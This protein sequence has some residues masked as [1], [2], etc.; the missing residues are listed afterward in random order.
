MSVAPVKPRRRRSGTA[1]WHMSRAAI[2]LS[3]VDVYEMTDKECL[4]LLVQARFGGWDTVRCPKCGSIDRHY[5]RF[6]DRRWKCKGCDKTFS[7]TSDSVFADRKLKLQDLLAGALLWINSSAGQPALELKRHF[8]KTYN[9][10]Y[11]L[12]H[13]LRE[14]LIRGYNVGLLNGDIEI[15]GAHQSGHRSDEKR[16]RPQGGKR[17][18]VGERNPSDSTKLTN[19]SRVKERQQL[20][21]EG[22]YDP[23]FHKKLPKDRRFFISVRKR[24]GIRGAGAVG[25]RVAVGLVED[26]TVATAVINDFVAKSESFL[27]T[28]TANAYEEAG[29]TFLEHR[30]VEHSE[31]L[32]GPNGENNN[33]A[34]ELNFRLDR[35]EKG[36]H[37]NIEPKY[38]LDYAVEMAFRADTRRM[39]NGSALRIALGIALNVG[40]SHYWRGFTRGRHRKVELLHPLPQSAPS[41][42]PEKGRDPLVA[43]SGRHPR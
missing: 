17:V 22:K 19:T 40:L 29:M 2:N 25:T 30:T 14:A 34:E 37:L 28:D 33:L 11:T 16:G 8:N 7:I 42:G 23:D 21:R 6:L 32:I 38:M 1:K 43:A 18:P 24:S 27:N 31:A 5:W 13:K 15:D 9:T 36:I 39:P 12:Q 10:A 20:I 35:A 26:K 41:S 4:E 3:V